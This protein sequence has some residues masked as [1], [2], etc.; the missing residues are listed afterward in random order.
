[1]RRKPLKRIANATK[2]TARECA[3]QRRPTDFVDYLAWDDRWRTAL[4]DQLD[5]IAEGDPKAFYAGAVVLLAGWMA[6]YDG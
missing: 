3:R 5:R 6:G 2:R 1:M 4:M